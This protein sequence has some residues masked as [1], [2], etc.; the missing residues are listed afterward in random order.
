MTYRHATHTAWQ[1]LD[2]ETIILN[3]K[4]RH[5]AGLNAS[6]G[7]IWQAM[8]EGFDPE[9]VSLDLPAD[10]AAEC[11]ESIERF[12][13]RLLELD[14]ICRVARD[15]AKLQPQTATSLPVPLEPPAVVWQE[16]MLA[17]VGQSCAFI[18]YESFVCNQ[19][20]FN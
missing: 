3:L 9:A 19:S 13:H 4:D 17:C 1:V 5:M 8:K 20:P 16:P 6:G 11:L 10:Q 15:G 12:V 14:L 7:V 18:P 2:G